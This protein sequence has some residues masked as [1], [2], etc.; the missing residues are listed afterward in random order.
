[1]GQAHA[2]EARQSYNIPGQRADQAL[3]AFARQS[4]R[5]ILFPYNEA[6]KHFT[7][8]LRGRYTET[9]ALRIL[10]R[11]AGLAIATNDDH[12]IALIVDHGPLPNLVDRILGRNRPT[13]LAPASDAAAA[14]VVELLDEI[15]VTANRKAD[16]LGRVPL[17]ITAVTQKALDESGVENLQDLS[18]TV[19][20]V[21]FRRNNNEGNPNVA[22]RG[23]ASQLGAPTTGIYLD[24]TPLQ[25]RDNP[26]SAS[27]N[28]SPFPQLFDLERVEILRGPQGT[29]YGSSAE[30]GAIRFISPAPS[31]TKTSVYAKTQ[32]SKTEGGGW[33]YETGIAMGGPVIPDKLGFR[34]SVFSRHAGGFIDQVSLYDSHTVAP[35]VNSGDSKSARI[36]LAWAATDRLKIT[37]ALY[38]SQDRVRAQDIFW[39]NIPRYTVN[40]GTFTNAGVVNG[41]RFDFP[42][43]A[44]AG[45]VYGPFNQFGPGKSGSALYQD[46][47]H[48]ATLVDSPRDT[49]MVLPT[50]TVD[51]VGRGMTVK[52]ITSFISDGTKG[53]TGGQVGERAAILPTATNAGFVDGLGAPVNGGLGSTPVFLPGFPNLEQ[54]FHFSNSRQGLVQE[55]RF[56][57]DPAAASLSWVGGVYVSHTV[58][59]Q[60]TYAVGNEDS[61]SVFLRG[62]SEA[63]L[64]GQTN[65]PGNNTSQRDL[66]ITETETAAFG[67][68]N[69]NLTAALK[70]TAG[71]RLTHGEIDLSQETGSS[72]QGAPSSFVGS[73]SSEVVTNP[74]CGANPLSC[75]SP[76]FHPFPNQAGDDQF[77]TFHGRQLENPV[78]PK[79][80]LSYQPDRRSL[81]YVSAAKGFRSGGL[82]QPAPVLTCSQD[83]TALG[84][85]GTPL[86]YNADSVW[87]YEAGAK[88][89]LLDGKAQVN[90]SAFYIDWKNPQLQNRLRCGQ[91]YIVNAGAAV[92]RGFDV[93][94]QTRLGRLTLSGAV[95]YTDAEYTRTYSIPDSAGGPIVMVNKGDRLGA[96]LWQTD[97]TAQYDFPVVGGLGGYVRSEYQFTSRYQRG[98]GPGASGYDPA[99]YEGS[100]T[101]FV[102]LRAGLTVKH[103]DVNLFVNNLTNSQDRIYENHLAT[104]P[105]VTA[106]TF[107]PREIGL[108][109]LFRY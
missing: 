72:V 33:S 80:G 23:I 35:D 40:S 78:T 107:R 45:G 97:L 49:R 34:A 88:I 24:D 62:V 28:G 38:Y 19:V 90:S 85:K 27:G 53:Y 60:F 55:L 65:F 13:F 95:A 58:Q 8:D 42:D 64:L 25:K 26:G 3:Q 106:S 67:E 108:Q 63:W 12:T 18:R 73:P 11:A 103:V 32:T 36:A 7:P 9:E 14:P 92:S 76:A 100:P 17:S 20:S 57:S 48:A 94:A 44:F 101:R 98:V 77:V 99:T 2:Q 96:P 4:G 37:P 31:L 16:L 81:Y 61:A 75:A 86:T 41:V 46:A 15:V 74:T 1:M 21:A 6:A 43:K 71:L 87:S 82:N 91:N 51:Y 70:L 50:L 29:L 93:Q 89:Q 68:L 104:S 84:L 56:A 69:Y 39:E 54:E 47:V 52:S 22:I 102:T 105:L 30:G 5:Q 109:A 79:F 59:H 10:A 66:H 83:L